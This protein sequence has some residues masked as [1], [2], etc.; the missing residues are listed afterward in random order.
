MSYADMMD[1]RD[2][3]QKPLAASLAMHLAVTG[4]VIGWTWYQDQ[5]KR[6][7]FGDPNS[8][9]GSVSVQP[10][11]GIPMPTRAP[12]NP[13]ANETESMVPAASK[14]EVRKREAEDPDEIA[15]GRKDLKK[16]KRKEAKEAVTKRFRED[17]QRPNQ[18]ASTT[19]AR[20]SSALFV[21]MAGGGGGIGMGTG[22]P[23]GTQFGWYAK[24]ISERVSQKWRTQDIDAR[25]NE[26]PPMIVTFDIQRDGRVQNVAVVRTSSNYALDASAKRAVTE[27]SPLPPL[28]EGFQRSSATVE[29]QFQFRR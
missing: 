26:A 1:Q 23:F 11:N 4:L 3:L 19:G 12:R 7:V 13:V 22:N 10:V 2:R 28:P 9:P 20:A 18:M 25:I 14:P 24:L 15:I 27:A 29:I 6:D 17:E 8:N 16:K 5:R 21:P